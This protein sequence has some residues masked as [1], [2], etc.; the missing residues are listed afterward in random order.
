MAIRFLVGIVL[1]VLALATWLT[2]GEIGLGPVKYFSAAV[3]V[4]TVLAGVWDFWVWRLPGIQR[5]P[6]VPRSVRGT[7]KGVLT[8]FWT[9]PATGQT[10]PPKIVFLV[11]RQTASLV[12]VTLL[13]DES[14]SSSSLADV[15]TNPDGSALTY[16]YLNRPDS[17]HEGRSR[18]HHGAVALDIAGAPARRLK[19]RYWTDRD[20]RGELDFQE[21]I[22]KLAEDFDEAEALFK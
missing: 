16:L 5:L 14:R 3:L 19:G 11:V 4:A 22:S 15:T 1:G 2:S 9:D 12:S 18:M 17:R 7:W 6:K 13:T 8:S 21:R 20:S 10:P